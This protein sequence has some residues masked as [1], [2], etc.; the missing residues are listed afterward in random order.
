MLEFFYELVVKAGKGF[1]VAQK[2][3]GHGREF[4]S[5]REYRGLVWVEFFF[6][7]VLT[8]SIYDR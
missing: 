6:A 5:S 1:A 2:K 7:H 8:S 3:T 4:L